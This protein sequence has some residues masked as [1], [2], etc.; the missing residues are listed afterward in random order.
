MTML[1]SQF[2]LFLHF[3]FLA[4][5]VINVKLICTIQLNVNPTTHAEVTV[6]VSRRH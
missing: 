5:V 6:T 1:A 3:L 4:T 2:L